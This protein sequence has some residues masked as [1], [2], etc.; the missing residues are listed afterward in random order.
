MEV[1]IIENQQL[2][3]STWEGGKTFE[4]FIFPRNALFKDRDFDFRMSSATL[5][6]A[7]SLFT[8]F[9]GYH[10][11]LIMLDNPLEMIRN[12]KR[13]SHP[14]R[15]IVEFN[16]ADE[17]QS[18]SLGKDFNLMIKEELRE[19]TTVGYLEETASNKDF[20][21]LFAL[22]DGRVKVNK[23]SYAFK[24]LDCMIVTN[25]HNDWVELK[26]NK[27]CLMISFNNIE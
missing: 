21:I 22:E 17:I 8:R 16:S 6:K 4:Y 2:I 23:E 27:K 9:K 1:E 20:L 7:P 26:G 10:R 12:G 3:P 14:A 11:F 24:K 18:F 15:E 19:K 5:D 13:E 25:P